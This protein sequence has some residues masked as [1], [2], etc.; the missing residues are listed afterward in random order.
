MYTCKRYL[1]SR[2]KWIRGSTKRVPPFHTAC[3]KTLNT[4]R[5]VNAVQRYIFRYQVRRTCQLIEAYSNFVHLEIEG[6]NFKE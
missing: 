2:M 4:L 5:L 3:R 1:A 6:I